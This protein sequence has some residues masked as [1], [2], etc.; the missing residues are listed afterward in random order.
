MTDIVPRI[1]IGDYILDCSGACGAP[2]LT[3]S[4]GREASL[5]IA[6]ETRIANGSPETPE[7]KIGIHFHAFY[8][9]PCEEIIGILLES[10]P[11]CE[12]LITT[13]TETKRLYLETLLNR[14]AEKR[15]AEY[16]LTYLIRVTP[17][18]GRNV[19]PLLQEGW[20]RLRYCDIVLH[21]HTKRSPHSS[22]GE[23]WANQLIAT[24]AGTSRQVRLVKA[25]FAADSQLGMVIPSHWEGIRHL[26]HWGANFEMACIISKALWPQFKLSIQA[27][28]VFPAGMMFWFR[29]SALEPLIAAKDL[30]QTPAHEPILND[31][32][33]F[34]ALE[35]LTL[36]ACEVAGYHWRYVSVSTKQDA[37]VQAITEPMSVWTPQPDAYLMGVCALAQHYRELQVKV[38][39]IE[40]LEEER[41][42]LSKQ[43]EHLSEELFERD[44]AIQ[45]M[46]AKLQDPAQTVAALKRH[47]LAQQQIAN[48]RIKG[49]L[50]S[51]LRLL[52]RVAS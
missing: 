15:E 18:Q 47:V 21:L 29:P 39:R 32:T 45:E 40:Q 9:E 6:N 25:A 14:Q 1:D 50:R 41:T 20:P 3:L 23:E 27:P 16:K 26:L 12:L 48:Q 34:H 17:N 44:L 2:S 11:D 30:M 24:L 52:S 10:I 38:N 8:T 4:E 35:R 22:S 33:S 13:D 37:D 36:H 31:G 43:L 51:F 46:A 7:L 49:S 19:L 42:T 28:I 5:C